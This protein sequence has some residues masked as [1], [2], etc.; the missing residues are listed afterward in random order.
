MKRFSMAATCGAVVIVLLAAA[1]RTV[2]PT[3]ST[4]ELAGA[5]WRLIELNGS[6]AIPEMSARPWLR[7]NTDSSR[8][9]GNFGCNNGAGSFTTGPNQSIRFGPI[10]T[11]RRACLNDQMNAQETALGAAV[12]ATDRY[13]ILGDTLE[14]RQA[15]KL[16]A[17]FIR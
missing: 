10:A 7:F 6:P 8:V 1:C 4:T 15:D 14:L 5:D 17:R 16:L 2:P 9:N 11:T 13:R 3:S 12:A